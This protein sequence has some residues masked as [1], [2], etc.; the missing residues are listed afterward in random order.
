MTEDFDEFPALKLGH[1]TS[2]TDADFVTDSGAAIFIM[3]VEFLRTLHDFFELRV[4]NTGD[5]FDNNRLI[6]ARGLDDTN[7]HFDVLFFATF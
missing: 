1:R 2:L 5:V 3:C 7:A 6:H 4:R